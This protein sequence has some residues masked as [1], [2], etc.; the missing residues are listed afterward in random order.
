ML[1]AAMEL[2]VGNAFTLDFRGRHETVRLAWQGMHKQLSLFVNPQGRCVLFQK[3]PGGLPAGGPAGAGGGRAL[4]MAA[5]RDAL[6]KISADP[7][8]LVH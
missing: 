3:A 6:R 5:T 7:G 4:T 8:R 2:Q 1:A